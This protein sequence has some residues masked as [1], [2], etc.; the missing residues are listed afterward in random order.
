[1]R[2]V[3]SAA[4]LGSVALLGPFGEP[5]SGLSFV[6]CKPGPH[7]YSYNLRDHLNLRHLTLSL[8]TDSLI[9][10]P[11]AASDPPRVRAPPSA[12]PHRRLDA[13]LDQLLSS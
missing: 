7:F 4:P 13:S 9:A 11:P 6:D 5:R 10:P 8:T 12:P 2:A 1:M 3:G